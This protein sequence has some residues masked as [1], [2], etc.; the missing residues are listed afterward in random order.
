MSTGAILLACVDTTTIAIVSLSTAYSP[1]TLTT[2]TDSY[3]TPARPCRI[4]DVAQLDNGRI[5]ALYLTSTTVAGQYAYKTLYSD[6]EGATWAVLSEVCALSTN[7]YEHVNLVSL[8]DI[9]LAVVSDNGT[10]GG[11]VWISSDGGASF[12]FTDNNNGWKSVRACKAVG[13][14]VVIASI[15]LST[16]LTQIGRAHV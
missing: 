6:D 8:G 4:C 3:G 1:T 10:N 16:T 2:I 11:E 5:V 12:T 9:L 7:L 15:S 13:A 14:G